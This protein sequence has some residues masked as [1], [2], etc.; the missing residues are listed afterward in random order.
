M[1]QDD[2]M[3]EVHQKILSILLELSSVARVNV[4]PSLFKFA[5]TLVDA[6]HPRR[7]PVEMLV[8]AVD[9][10]GPGRLL[11]FGCGSAP[12]RL[13]IERIGCDYTG[14]DLV[15]TTGHRG[16]LVADD[17]I[18]FYNGGKLPY[19]DGAFDF[20]YTNQ[21]FEHVLDPFES[22]MECSRVLRTDG[23]FVGAVSFLE[24]YHAYQT[25]GYTPYG[26]SRI[27]EGSG[28]V[29]LCLTANRDVLQILLRKFQAVARLKFTDIPADYPGVE[30]VFEKAF[31]NLPSTHRASFMLQFCGS[32]SFMYR[33]R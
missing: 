4:D 1:N 21:V 23:R 2:G 16:D 33:K 6:Q 18:H 7:G 29:P 5:S 10:I 32:F 22:M 8:A 14:V 9:A 12:H 11:D 31:L 30:H 27:A 17:K 26:F 24:P 3:T 28:L 20:V 19:P 15:E 13:A 25:F